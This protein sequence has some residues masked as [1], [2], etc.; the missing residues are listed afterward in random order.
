MSCAASSDGSLTW[1][2]CPPPTI[3]RIYGYASIDQTLHHV[4]VGEEAMVAGL[5]VF[6]TRI[7]EGMDLA[8]SAPQRQTVF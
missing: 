8:L 2:G 5:A 4:G 3:Q 6:D 7:R 1:P